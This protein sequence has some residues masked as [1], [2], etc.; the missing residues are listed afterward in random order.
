MQHETQGEE[1]G[2]V[3]KQKIQIKAEGGEK[4]GFAVW[5]NLNVGFQELGI[6]KK[7]KAVEQATHCDS[8]RK[9]PYSLQEKLWLLKVWE[10]MKIVDVPEEGRRFVT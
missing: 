1:T 3:F 8:E 4:Q 5:A 6:R 10:S 2:E 9:S 7:K